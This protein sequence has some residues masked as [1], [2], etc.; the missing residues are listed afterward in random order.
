MENKEND[1]NLEKT[2]RKNVNDEFDNSKFYTND[3]GKHRQKK[4]KKKQRKRSSISSRS[5]SSSDDSSDLS[6]DSSRSSSESSERSRSRKHKKK[7]KKHKKYKSKRMKENK[8]KRN[9]KEKSS[10]EPK[11]SKW[12]TVNPKSESPMP[13]RTNVMREENKDLDVPVIED[14]NEKAENKEI[15]MEKP[16]FKPSGI[17]AKETNTVK[18]IY[19]YV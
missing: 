4:S 1:E 3:K 15:E 2:V 11:K 14:I 7:S 18:Y 19:C 9:K 8:S 16:N 13:S 12:T 17:L 5:S 6:S 10:A